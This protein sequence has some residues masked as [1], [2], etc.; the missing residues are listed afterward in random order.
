M[1]SRLTSFF[2][3]DPKLFFFMLPQITNLVIVFTVCLITT[4]NNK[5]KLLTRLPYFFLHEPLNQC[6]F[7]FGLSACIG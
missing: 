6:I 7:Y 4:A 5:Q 2:S 3:N 1:V